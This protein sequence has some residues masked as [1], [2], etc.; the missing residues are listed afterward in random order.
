M[1]SYLGIIGLLAANYVQAGDRARA[2]SL[3]APL[4]IEGRTGARSM[5]FATFHAVCSEFE[6]VEVSVWPF[7]AAFRKSP[8]GRAVLQKMNLADV[9]RI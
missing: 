1:P 9:E 3:L 6:L 7:Y 8:R 4:A 2:Q 5:A